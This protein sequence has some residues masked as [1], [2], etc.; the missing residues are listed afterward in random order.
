M[1]LENC[2]FETCFF[3]HTDTDQVENIFDLQAP[4]LVITLHIAQFNSINVQ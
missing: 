4:K 3:T 1:H 2:D